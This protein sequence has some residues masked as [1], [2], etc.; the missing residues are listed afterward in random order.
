MPY[1]IFPPFTLSASAGKQLQND[2]QFPKSRRCNPVCIQS[3]ASGYSLLIFCSVIIS[4]WFDLHFI[5]II[6]DGR[7][8]GQTNKVIMQTIQFVFLFGGYTFRSLITLKMFVRILAMTAE[9]SKYRGDGC[10]SLRWGRV[11]Q[12]CERFIGMDGKQMASFRKQRNMMMMMPIQVH[13]YVWIYHLMDYIC[14]IF[15]F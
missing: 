15:F 13:E 1:K 7:T 14:L 10:G 6:H 4:N 2:H 5:I 8:D 12:T 11:T 9:I 3:W